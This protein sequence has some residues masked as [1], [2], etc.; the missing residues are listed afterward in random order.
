MVSGQNHF[1]GINGGASWTNAK[2]SN[3]FPDIENRT[4]LSIGLTYDDIF[5]NYYSVGAHIIYNQHG[6]TNEIVLV[7]DLILLKKNNNFFPSYST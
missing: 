3:F 6:F 7:D 1:L 2:T 4:G 5:K